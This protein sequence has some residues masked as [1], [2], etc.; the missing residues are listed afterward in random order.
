[1]IR[2][3]LTQA[4]YSV[5]L[6]LIVTGL[7]VHANTLIGWQFQDRD[8]SYLQRALEAGKKHQCQSY[9]IV[10]QYRAF[11]ES[12]FERFGSTLG[13]FTKSFFPPIKRI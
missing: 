5:C 4:L 6:F 10:M 11:S 8:L 12:R 2:R 7:S 9:R 1:M 3:H 13:R